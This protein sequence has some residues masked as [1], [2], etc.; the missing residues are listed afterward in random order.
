MFRSGQID[1]PVIGRLVDQSDAAIVLKAA[2]SIDG[3]GFMWQISNVFTE[4]IGIYAKE[5]IYS[6]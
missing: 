6:L 5:D 2:L 3:S 1:H 4:P